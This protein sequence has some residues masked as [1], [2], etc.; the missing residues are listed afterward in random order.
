DRAHQLGLAVLLDVVYNHLGPDGNY[1]GV[2]SP[3]FASARHHSPWGQAMNF[4]G[5]HSE[6]VRAFFIDNALHWLHE[7]HLD[8][9]RLDATHA[10]VD[11]S[12]RHFLAELSERVRS[13]VTGRH[14]YLIA[15]DHRN[16]AKMVEP[17]ARGGWGL[18]GVWAD[19]FHHEMRRLLAGDHEGYYR[20]YSG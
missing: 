14:V 20:D 11:D 10:I 7:Y 18:D 19:D 5:E 6:M 9:L 2:Y 13:A 16:L 17:V 1:L 8:G 15:E 4:D 3:Y 12:P